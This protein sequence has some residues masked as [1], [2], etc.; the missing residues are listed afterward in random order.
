VIFVGR[1]NDGSC[2]HTDADDKSLR[3]F[4][5]Q[6]HAAGSILPRPDVSITRLQ[7]HACTVWALVVKPSSSTPVS[8]G[9]T[10]YIRIGSEDRKADARQVVTLTER[11][12][13]ATFDSRPVNGATLHD[14]DTFY[15]QDQYIPKAV[16]PEVLSENNRT[17][18]EQLAALRILTPTFQPTNLGILVAGKD[19]RR[20]LPGAYVQFV[21][22]DGLT[23]GDPV[24][25]SAEISGRL[26]DVITR[27][28]DKVRI[29]IATASTIDDSGRRVDHPDYPFEALRELMINAIAHRDY[30]HSNAPARLYW[31]DDR[32]EIVS[33]GEPYGVVTKENFGTPDV[34]DYRNIE[35]V[36]VLKQLGFI[37]RFGVGIARARQRIAANGNPP[38]EF[39]VRELQNFVRV[40]V[41]S[42]LA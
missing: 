38:I 35:L 42:A 27:T 4:I 29:N 32:V 30:E 20:F 12:I 11:R 33:P 17:L 25:D 3:D 36:A 26:D 40:T 9:G 2:T 31:F 23:L 6:L 16:S 15:L 8:Y 34:T 39:G 19:V 18:D 1:E 24:K 28:L 10:V 21:R 37:E 5:D 22:V 14:L 41:R 7:A 13:G